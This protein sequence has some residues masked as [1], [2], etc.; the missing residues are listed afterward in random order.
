MLPDVCIRR[1]KGVRRLLLDLEGMEF[2][3]LHKYLIDNKEN[4]LTETEGKTNLL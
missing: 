1:E 2:S 3:I 4:I